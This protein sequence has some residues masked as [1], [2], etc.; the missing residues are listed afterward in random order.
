VEG[1]ATVATVAPANPF[2]STTFRAVA[3]ATALAAAPATGA[4]VAAAARLARSAA[5]WFCSLAT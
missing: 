5:R 2:S 4:G 1:T 3:T